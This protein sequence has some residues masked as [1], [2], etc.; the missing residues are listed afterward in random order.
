MRSTICGLLLL[1]GAT[2]SAPA[3]S[4]DGASPSRP[5]TVVTVGTSLTASIDWQPI[6]AARL[7]RC[8]GRPVE[9]LRVAESGVTSRWGLEQI[10]RIAALRPDFVI[11]EFAMNDANWR[12]FVSRAESRANI[13]AIG[14]RLRER[15]PD[16]S[17]HLMTTNVV[18]GLRGL[19]RPNVDVFYGQ[20]RA[21]AA[22]E[23]W[24]LIDIAPKWRALSAKALTEAIPDGIHPTLQA[25]E[26]VAIPEIVSALCPGPR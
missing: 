3:G 2:A 26:A 11:I 23:G 9:V 5:T 8:W 24:G 6:L 17:I 19:M 22:S 21:V 13:V 1:A 14:R 16:V 12:R 25:F 20:Y 4:T 15:L 7:T 18:H 10:D